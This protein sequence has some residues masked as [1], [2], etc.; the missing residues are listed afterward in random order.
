LNFL[1]ITFIFF[2]NNYY[3]F[4]GVIR[5]LDFSLRILIRFIRV[6]MRI[7][8]FGNGFYDFHFRGCCIFIYNDRLIIA[9]I[10]STSRIRPVIF[11]CYSLLKIVSFLL[12]RF[13]SSFC[14]LTIFSFFILHCLIAQIQ[15]L[16]YDISHIG[17]RIRFCIVEL[18]FVKFPQTLLIL[19][20]IFTS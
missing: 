19:S 6:M 14:S 9:C 20:F 2:S 1:L 12:L 5:L 16:N 10:A 3:Y 17:C 18:E 4:L 8:C 13:I 7:L 15:L 11:T